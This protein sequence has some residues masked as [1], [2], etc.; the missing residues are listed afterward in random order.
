MYSVNADRKLK[1]GGRQRQRSMPTARGGQLAKIHHAAQADPVMAR[2][3]NRPDVD[4]GAERPD[5]GAGRPP[6]QGRGLDTTEVRQWARAQ[7]TAIRT[8]AAY[9]AR[10]VGRLRAV[11][12]R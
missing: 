4:S 9:R 6:D 7:G 11:T 8:V 2:C 12:G 10:V 1:P 3:L 5:G